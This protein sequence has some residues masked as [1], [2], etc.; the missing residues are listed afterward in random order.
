MQ[1][2]KKDLVFTIKIKSLPSNYKV[3]MKYLLLKEEID[4]IKSV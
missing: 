1:I 4:E 2:Y 3:F